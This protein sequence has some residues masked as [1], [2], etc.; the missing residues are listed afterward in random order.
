MALEAL[1][2]NVPRKK[3]ME[4]LGQL[5]KNKSLLKSLKLMARRGGNQLQ[6]KQDACKSPAHGEARA[7]S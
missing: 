4:E 7:E 2:L 1:K 3:S 5:E 6:E